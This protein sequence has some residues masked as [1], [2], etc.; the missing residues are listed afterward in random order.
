MFVILCLSGPLGASA[1]SVD[2][3]ARPLASDSLEFTGLAKALGGIF[4]QEKIATILSKLPPKCKIFGYDIGDYSGDDGMDVV[5]SVMRDDA[6]RRTLDVLFFL[7]EGPGFRLLRSLQRRYVIEPIEVGFS[8]ERGICHVT[9][10]TGEYAWRITGYSAADG[11]FRRASEWTTDRMHVGDRATNVGY[12][13]SFSYETLL[14][15]EHY[16][17]ANSGKTFIRQKYYD[18]P[19]YPQDLSLPADMPETVGD[20][21]G[22]MITRGG[23]SW[24]GPD[25]CSLFVSAR[26][27]SSSVQFR[28]R[29]HDDRLLYHASADSADHLDLRFDLSGR[30]RVR[31]DGSLQTFAAETQF[32]LRV[33][34]GDGERRTPTVELLEDNGGSVAVSDVA[35]T[36][37]EAEGEY[38]TYDFT[39]RVPLR[40]FERQKRLRTAGFV[41]AYHDVDNPHDLRWV[42]IAATA[43]AYEPGEP[44]SYGRLHFVADP[45]GEYEWEDLRVTVLA[46]AL[47]RAGLLP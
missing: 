8:I 34:M 44:N 4:S 14:A 10:K 20:S 31:P 40:L 29:V 16:Y 35:V 38:Q 47:R 17:G 32:G 24:Y 41:C 13:R 3:A 36:L 9:E 23:S 45:A 30:N 28:L 18:L 33:F 43:R 7:N 22:L 2:V 39:L 27:D 19:V 15:E 46:E 25:D 1:G 21:T 42:S 6:P 26:Y 12:E 11:A 5:L 37:Q